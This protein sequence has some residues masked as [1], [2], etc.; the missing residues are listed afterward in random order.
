MVMFMADLTCLTTV[1]IYLGDWPLLEGP[2]SGV[3]VTTTEQT[4]GVSSMSRLYF[5]NSGMPSPPIKR[6]A[7][8]QEVSGWTDYT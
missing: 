8:A 6:T 3:T 5:V 1:Y 2:S 7:T 4:E